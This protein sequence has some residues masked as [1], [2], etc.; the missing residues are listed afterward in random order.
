M[1]DSSPHTEN[2]VGVLVSHSIP[3]IPGLCGEERGLE[4]KLTVLG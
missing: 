1:V 4:R 2:R 3:D